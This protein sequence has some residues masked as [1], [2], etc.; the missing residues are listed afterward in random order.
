MSNIKRKSKKGAALVMALAM[1]ASVFA[2]MGLTVEEASAA[3]KAKKPAKMTIAKVESKNQC[4]KVSWKKA[5][6][7]K[8]GKKKRTVNYQL[9]VTTKDVW[10]KTSTKTYNLKNK[11]VSKTFYDHPGTKYTFRVRGVYVNRG[12]TVYGKWS[13]AKRGCGQK[14][15]LPSLLFR[16]GDSSKAAARAI[17]FLNIQQ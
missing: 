4:A 10:G 1:L 11:T 12:K 9:K 17:P 13:A 8:V 7:V 2:V 16:P 6:K 3:A 14:S 5:K 15:G